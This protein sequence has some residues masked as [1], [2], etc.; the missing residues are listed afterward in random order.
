MCRK[1][2]LPYCETSSDIRA[3]GRPE[4]GSDIASVPQARLRSLQPP[5]FPGLVCRGPRGPQE[6]ITLRITPGRKTPRAGREPRSRTPRAGREPRYKY[7]GEGRDTNTACTGNT[8]AI[9]PPPRPCT[10]GSPLPHGGT[11]E[12]VPGGRAAGGRGGRGAAAAVPRCHGGNLEWRPGPPPH[13]LPAQHRRARR[14]RREPIAG[15]RSG[16]ARA[17]SCRRGPTSRES[18]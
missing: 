5:S 16:S 2:G 4:V 3:T 15:R 8:C 10:R 17:R 11:A 14:R 12:R 18:G 13:S 9:P 6:P 7:A 1:R